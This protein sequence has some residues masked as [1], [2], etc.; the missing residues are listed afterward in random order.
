MKTV[1][2]PLVTLLLAGFTLTA[3]AQTVAFPDAGLN[4]AVRDALQIPSA[5]LTVQNLLTLTNL[6][7]SRRNVRS[8]AGLEVAANLVSLNLQINRLTNFSLPPE[9]TKLM[10]LNVSSNPLTNCIL[11]NGLTNLTALIVESCGLTNFSLPTG[12]ARLNTLDL[13]NNQLTRLA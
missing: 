8:I 2:H 3:R 12:L 10:I 13:A 1:L 5:P 4:A 11:P 7:A 9:L 6:D